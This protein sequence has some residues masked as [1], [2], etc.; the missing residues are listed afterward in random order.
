[1]ATP[2][3]VNGVTGVQATAIFVRGENCNVQGYHIFNNSNAVAFV[4]FYDEAEPTV[5]TTVP[6]WQAAVPTL[7][8]A[9]MDFGQPG[10]LFFRHG[11]WVAAATT[12]NGNTNPSA[13]VVVNLAMS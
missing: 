3:L 13:V 2:V 8:D 5:G 7:E 9:F 10:G 11:L 1:M 12:A 4:N 6:K